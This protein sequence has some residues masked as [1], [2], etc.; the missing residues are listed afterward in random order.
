MSKGVKD[1][2]DVKSVNILIISFGFPSLEPLQYR[3]WPLE[4]GNWPLV[5]RSLATQ[6]AGG[7]P[8]EAWRHWRLGRLAI[9]GLESLVTILEMFSHARIA[10]SL[11]NYSL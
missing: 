8:L 3:Y 7:W 11:S 9:G 4:A 1:V 10:G 2:K 5:D 6:G